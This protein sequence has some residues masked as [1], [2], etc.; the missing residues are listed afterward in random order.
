MPYAA[1]IKVRRLKTLL[2]QLRHSL[3]A[4]VLDLA[5]WNESM[6][7]VSEFGMDAFRKGQGHLRNDLLMPTDVYDQIMAHSEA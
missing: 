3:H 2:A 6:S 5:P 4:L 1:G 7:N